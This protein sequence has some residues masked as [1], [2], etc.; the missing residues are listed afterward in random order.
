MRFAGRVRR[1]E[2]RLEY[3]HAHTMPMQSSVHKTLARTDVGVDER[4][5]RGIGQVDAHQFA[6]LA[7]VRLNHTDRDIKDTSTLAY[8]LV[9]NPGTSNQ[10]VN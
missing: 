1:S 3:S 8:D 5:S 9:W 4:T 6:R 10:L 7:L 2:I